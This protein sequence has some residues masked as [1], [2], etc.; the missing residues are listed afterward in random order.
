MQLFSAIVNIVRNKERVLKGF[1]QKDPLDHEKKNVESIRVF[2]YHEGL[3]CFLVK[4]LVPR[5]I[6]IYSMESLLIFQQTNK[7]K[8]K[9]FIL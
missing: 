5:Y 7:N 8:G 1:M 9:I 3:W 4:F 6:Y 2:I